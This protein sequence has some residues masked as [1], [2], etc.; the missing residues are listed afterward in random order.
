MD[1]LLCQMDLIKSV[2]DAETSIVSAINKLTDAIAKED[3]VKEESPE[4]KINR[5]MKER[6]KNVFAHWDRESI[7]HLRKQC[8]TLGLPSD[9]DRLDVIMRIIEWCKTNMKKALEKKSLIIY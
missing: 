2:K 9:G 7:E 6:M 3:T 4:E 1:N 5:K 8:I